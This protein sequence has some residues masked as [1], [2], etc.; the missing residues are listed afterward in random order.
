[1]LFISVLFFYGETVAQIQL[2]QNIA[3]AQYTKVTPEIDG[4]VDKIWLKSNNQKGFF[5]REPNEGQI[6]T[7]DTRFYALYDEKNIYLLFVMLDDAPQSIP[8]RLVERDH[9]FYPDDSINF[10][11]DTY[12][13]NRTA[14]YYSTNPLGIKQDG[15]ISENGENI[16]M[17]WDGIFEVDARINQYGWVAE[18]A[19]PFKTLRFND[20]FKYQ[21]WGFN[22][23][24]IRKKS[25]EISYWSLVDQNFRRF[26]L[27]KDGVLIGMKNIKSGQNLSFLPYTTARGTQFPSAEDE[28]DSNLG[29]DLKYG[30]T[31]DLTL[32]LT[33]NPDFGQVEIDEEQINLDKRFE[34]Q[35]EEKRP[36]F[37][38]NSTLFQ[39]PFYQLFYS[40]RI[41][42]QSDIK[43]GAK[44]TGKVGPY[45]IGALTT[46]TG[47][48]ENTGLGDPDKPPTDELFSVFRLQRD[49]LS[50]SNIGAM[51]V[52]RQANWGGDSHLYNRAASVDWTVYS[53]Q[54]YFIGQGVYSFNSN[55][56]QN[57]DLINKEGG[58]V[59][60]QV[61]HYGR[62]FW[63]DL[64]ATYYEPD[65][66]IDSTGFFQKL[67]GKGHK[68]VSLYTDMHPF[69]NGK[70][71][72]SWGMSVQPILLK[73]SDGNGRLLT[74]PA[75]AAVVFSV[76]LAASVSVNSQE[77][78]I[79]R[80][81]GPAVLDPEPPCSIST[82][83]AIRGFFEGAYPTNQAWGRITSSL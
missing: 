61:G 17:S 52:D 42:A 56:D 11:L 67:A 24:R 37:L 55:R 16:D 9:R 15:L 4:K 63:F 41:G 66:N 34:V 58:A 65:F 82:T 79:S 74:A 2:P 47:G 53:G 54:Q 29:L 68:Q 81:M 71:I 12:N 83:T 19:I 28:Y 78:I 60:G 51:Y 35:L 25:R 69:V 77:S 32:D 76:S 3:I 18:F 80:A 27:D 38:E 64:S 48:W 31:S 57:N 73:D 43:G 72:R 44:F 8:A 21:V 70:I 10:Y 14:F 20:E 33:L 26:R 50:N 1:M 23:F 45:S 39:T 75:A 49:I 22:V 5:Q 36:F 13:D 40:R 62:T 46:L 59:Y 30:V 6:A 7:N